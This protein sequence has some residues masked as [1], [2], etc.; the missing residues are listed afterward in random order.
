MNISQ[1][2]LE[3]TGL[4]CAFGVVGYI[5]KIGFIDTGRELSG[6]PFNPSSRTDTPRPTQADP[7]NSPR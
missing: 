2:A 1:A 5:Y 7:S 4:I 6:R 3:I